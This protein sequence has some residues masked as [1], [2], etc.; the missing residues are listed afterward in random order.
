M[1]GTVFRQTQFAEFELRMHERT[2]RGEA[3]TGDDLSSMYEEIVREAYGHTEGVCVV[4]DEIRAEWAYIPH[5]YYNFYVFQ[6]AT[7]Y[8]ASSLL[9]ER[10]LAGDHDTTH[11]HLNLLSSGGSDYPIEQLRV[12]GVDMTT[13]EPLAATMRRMNRIM[14]EIESLLTRMG[15]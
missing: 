5:F 6:Y 4:D 10:V 12:A 11:R 3:L 9:A 15:R 1:K 7:S 2:E 13:E 8:T 14:D